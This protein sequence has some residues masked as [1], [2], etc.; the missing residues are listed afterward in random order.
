MKKIL[1]SFFISIIFISHISA[2]LSNR[3]YCGGNAY[4]AQST[5]AYCSNTFR[6]WRDIQKFSTSSYYWNYTDSV[7]Q[8][9]QSVG[10]HT[11][12]TLK[13]TNPFTPNDTVPG[14]PAWC[15]DQN[16]TSDNASA[17]FPQGT[18]TTLWKNFVN[19]IV[20]RY[21]GD[22]TSDMPGLIYPIT[23]WHVIGQEWQRI[24]S[25]DQALDTTC[26][27]LTKDTSLANTKKF[28]QLVNM[29]YTAIKNQEPGSGSEVSFAGIDTRNQSEAFYDGYFPQTTLCKS[30]CINPPQNVSASQLAAAPK[31][32]QTR[33][34]VMYIFKNAKFDEVDLHEYGRWKNIPDI[35]KWA[36]DS[37][38]NKRVTFLEG[39]GPFCQACENIYHAVNDTDG[40][41]PALLVRDNASYVVYYFITGFSAG[42]KKMHWNAGPE[43]SDWGSTWGDLDL[44]TINRI[45]KPSFYVYRWLAK[46]LFSNT[47]ADTVVRIINANQNLYHYQVQQLP[48]FVPF[49]DVAWS[50]NTT[51]SIIVSGTGTLYTWDIPITCDSLYPTA[52]D[53]VF[54]MNTFSVSGSH[55]IALNNGVPVFYSWNN[56]LTGTNQIENYKLQLFIYPNPFNSSTTLQ[57]NYNFK[58]ATLTV[59]N[60]FGQTVAQIKNING[61]TITFNRDNLPSGIYFLRLTAPSPS[62]GEGGGSEVF[63]GKLVITDK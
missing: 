35:A 62:Q 63:T 14:T 19:A 43:Y 30:D 47:S 3:F 50:T 21:D 4:V 17:W 13:C 45:H 42:V 8:S 33:R 44:R 22:G 40:R 10:L 57:T 2:Q 29:T 36:K 39:G 61:Q 38:Q 41:L 18:D 51:D 32:L 55:T 11:M 1:L 7:I 20:E 24:W 53:S 60:S 31:F 9:N 27:L 6:A 52:C 16:Q 59:Y 23:E 15:F 25:S 48:T 37:A 12:I 49:I 56:I 34:N 46:T 58:D 26:N 28:V 5:G 54:P